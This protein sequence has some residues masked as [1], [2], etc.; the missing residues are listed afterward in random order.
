MEQKGWQDRLLEE[1]L[2]G[3]RQLHSRNV[4][5]QAAHLAEKWGADPERAFFAGFFHDICKEMPREEQLQWLGKSDI[6][7]DELFL[8]QPKIW[9]GFA[10]AEYLRCELNVSDPDILNAVRYHTTA[11]AGMSLLEQIIYLADLTSAERDYP[12]VAVMQKLVDT[13]LQDAML[14]ALQY[15]MGDLVKRRVPVC[16]FTWEAYNEYALR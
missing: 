7:V 5:A 4:A 8:K 1:K 9:H 6:I 13:S 15:I 14:Y 16:S 2:S 3:F 11:R 10:A 12:D